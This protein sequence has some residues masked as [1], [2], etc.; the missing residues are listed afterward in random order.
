M[1]RLSSSFLTWKYL[2]S[3]KGGA[4]FYIFERKLKLHAE[5]KYFACMFV[6]P[7]LL[8]FYLSWTVE[9]FK[10]LTSIERINFYLFSG[11]IIKLIKGW[12]DCGLGKVIYYT[13][14]YKLCQRI[15]WTRES[16]KNCD[17][18]KTTWR[19]LKNMKE[20]YQISSIAN[21]S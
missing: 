2:K 18:W 8:Q 12:A 11:F 10:L 14:L 6:P 20:K 4:Y 7:S 19:L 1:Q 16:P 5:S 13:F 15:Q 9:Q 3:I 21:W 17:T